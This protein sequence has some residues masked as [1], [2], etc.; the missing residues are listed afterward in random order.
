MHAQINFIGKHFTIDYA[1]FYILNQWIVIITDDYKYLVI[2]QQNIFLNFA[3]E[4]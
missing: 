3:R 4:N 2:I 1:A